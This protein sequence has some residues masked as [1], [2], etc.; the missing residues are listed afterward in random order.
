LYKEKF[1]LSGKVAI[2]TGGNRGLGLAMSQALVEAGA[3]LVNVCR[4]DSRELEELVNSLHGSIKTL[5][6]DL[7]DINVMD[8]IIKET[9]QEFGKIDILVNN[10]G[11]TIRKPA[12]EYTLEDWNKI[13][14]LDLTSAFFMCQK[15]A[16]EFI[17]S[18]TRGKIISTS[19]IVAFQGGKNNAPYTASKSGISGFTKTL[20]NELG[21]YGINVN[22][23]APG[24]M[25]TSLTEE[26]FNNIERNNE[27]NSRIPLRRWGT[28]EDVGALC[29]F[30]ASAAS[31]YVTGVTILVDGGWV[32][33]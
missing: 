3:S 9:K 17:A 15:V 26:V 32:S 33:N 7:S 23:I 16:Q 10:A 11:M 6:Y 21:K 5:N 24:Y 4:S 2:I 13:I 14:N 18:G 1:D 27:I 25:R 20:A 30:L 31:D 8:E 19:S 29:L 22:A 12:I 28:P